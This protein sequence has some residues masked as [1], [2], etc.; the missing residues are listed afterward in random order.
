VADARGDEEHALAEKP[1]VA[2]VVAQRRP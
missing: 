2:H 1:P